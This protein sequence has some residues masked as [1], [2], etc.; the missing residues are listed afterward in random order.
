[1]S[2]EKELLVPPSHKNKQE[3]VNESPSENVFS[4]EPQTDIPIPEFVD[5]NLVNTF[6]LIEQ[7]IPYKFLKISNNIFNIVI[8][9]LFLRL[10]N[11]FF[12]FNNS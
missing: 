1:M 6:T 12:E 2:E 5:K 10:I 4:S 7:D 9:R 8:I 11:N 3:P